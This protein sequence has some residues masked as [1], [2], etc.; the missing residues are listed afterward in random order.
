MTSDDFRQSLTAAEPPAELT[1]ALAGLWW[2]AKGDWTRAHE[3]AQ[4]DEGRGPKNP[5]GLPAS[6]GRRSEQRS[7]ES[8]RS[9][10]SASQFASQSIRKTYGTNER[11]GRVGLPSTR[12][13][14]GANG[15]PNGTRNW[16]R[17]ARESTWGI[18]SL[19]LQPLVLTMLPPDCTSENSHTSTASKL[20]RFHLLPTFRG[21][22]S[23][24]AAFALV[25][26]TVVPLG[27]LRA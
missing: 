26:S 10:L 21:D 23:Y 11:R 17:L 7:S 27:G 25:R 19:N 6:Q 5:R 12:A 1:F 20:G 18:T 16:E 14:A 3:S 24:K 4:Q 8:Q 22:S 15:L 13:R 9:G 2:D